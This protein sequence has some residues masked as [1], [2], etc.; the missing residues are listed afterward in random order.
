[1]NQE[2]IGKFIA[3]NR[4]KQKLT[5]EQLAEKLHVSKN[6]VSKWERGLNLP[7]VSLMEELCQVLKISLNELFAGEYLK[8]QDIL[9]QSE[10]NILSILKF[11]ADLKKKKWKITIIL[12]ILLIVIINPVK[13]FLVKYGYAINDNLRH[14]QRYEPGKSNIKGEVN[15]YYYENIN[16]D[17]EIKMGMLFLKIPSELI[18][19]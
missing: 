1:M 10:K 9:E 17:F 12:A 19:D 5:Q 11:N 7:D 18:K 3:D 6:A 16:M 13:C 2:K 4:K 15:T 8:K 14:C